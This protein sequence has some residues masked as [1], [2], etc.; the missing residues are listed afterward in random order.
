[1]KSLQNTIVVVV[2]AFIT[3]QLPA[4]RRMLGSYGSNRRDKALLSLF[5]GTFSALGIWVGFPLL[6]SLVSCKIVGVVAGG[7]L[8]GPIVGLGAGII[9]AIP[10]YFLGGFTTA[11]S[12]VANL[13]IGC[14]AGLV[15]LRFGLK[16]IDLRIAL[17][18]ALA[19]ELILK[20]LILTMSKP[21]AAAWAL[22]KTIALPTTIANSF[23]LVLFVY[24]VREVFNQRERLQA[25]SAQNAMLV[26]KHTA[27]LLRN[28]LTEETA[29][30]VAETIYAH[31]DAAAVAITDKVNILAFVGK[32]A[33]H[34]RAGFPHILAST[35]FVLDHRMPVISNDRNAIGC[36]HEA[37]PLTAVVD[38]PLLAEQELLGSVKIFKSGK[39]IVTPYEAEL[40]QGIADFLSLQL[41]QLKLDELEMLR[42]QAEYRVLKAQINP[43]FLYN[44]L[45]TI[46]ALVTR[47]PEVCRTLIK[48]LSDFMRRTLNSTDEIGTLAEELEI[49]RKYIRIEKARFGERVVMVEQIPEA[50]LGGEVPVFSLQPL[51]ENAVKHGLSPR[52]T[53]GTVRISA[54]STGEARYIEVQDNGAGIPEAKLALLLGGQSPFEPAKGTGI[55]L[56]NVNQRLRRMF[57]ERFGLNVRSTEGVGTTVTVCL[58]LVVGGLAA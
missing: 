23:G 34:H 48:D 31:T 12:I 30:R 40:I 11:A 56:N 54:W 25:E 41:L 49:V 52:S 58:P 5:F 22:E 51:V 13:A 29:L 45:G 1:V 43:H 35:R 14:F 46:R 7:L 17:A 19:S 6:G 53:G 15:N 27:G 24:I 20:V 2:A 36:S 3:T 39:D 8:G 37:C 47:E 28:G 10:R 50:M 4:F 57:G 44:T 38:V 21:F 33:D 16:R 55:G 32:G 9:G 18:T 26:I 42:S